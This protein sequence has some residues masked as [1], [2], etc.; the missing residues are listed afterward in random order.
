LRTYR[1]NATRQYL[2]GN[3]TERKFLVLIIHGQQDKLFPA[4]FAREN[5][6]KYA[7]KGQE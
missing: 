2:P 1:E 7:R 3:I 5:R 6:D 4:A